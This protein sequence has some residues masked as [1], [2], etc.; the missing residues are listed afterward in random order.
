MLRA[1]YRQKP[2]VALPLSL[3]AVVGIASCGSNT[4]LD[5]YPVQGKVLFQGQPVPLASVALHPVGRSKEMKSV[6][7]HG[8]TN[9]NG[10]FE[11]STFAEKDGAPVGQYKVTVL[12]CGPDPGTDL[13]TVN[14]DTIWDQPERLD[15]R[16]RNPDKTPLQ[17]N[18]TAG[19][20]TLE[21][22]VV[23]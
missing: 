18:I 21:P 8:E 6:L 5:V 23:E 4:P 11:V 17:V 2:N 16:Y 20:N 15:A 1:N 13:S 14:E 10:E 12:W 3:L 22:F 19:T 7:P 9:A